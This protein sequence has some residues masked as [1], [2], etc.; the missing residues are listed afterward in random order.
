MGQEH[1]AGGV[2]PLT[3]PNLAMLARSLGAAQDDMAELLASPEDQ[4]LVVVQREAVLFGDV[5]LRQHEDFPPTI[6]CFDLG[7]LRN[8]HALQNEK[9][10]ISKIIL[11][12]SR[13]RDWLD[14][15]TDGVP[16]IMLHRHLGG[17]ISTRLSNWSLILLRRL[18]L[19]GLLLRKKS[20]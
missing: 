10:G 20:K 13:V 3:D 17:R 11:T 7:Y 8:N 4:W 19:L 12:R 6:L 15:T 14:R 5:V 1:D 16:L 18:G 9:F 2:V